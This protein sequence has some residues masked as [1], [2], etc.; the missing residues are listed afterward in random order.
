ML[1]IPPETQPR[2]GGPRDLFFFTHPE[3]WEH[4]PFLP[5]VRRHPDDTMDCGVLYDGVHASGLMGYSTAVFLQN[6]FLLPPT[7][8]ALLALPKEAFDAPEELLRAGWTV[9]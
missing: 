8:E 4:W 5:V 6:I 9:D 1:V 3:R 7:E 2:R